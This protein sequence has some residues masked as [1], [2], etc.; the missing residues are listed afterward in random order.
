M[1]WIR[2]KNY[3]HLFPKLLERSPYHRRCK[4]L[5]QITELMRGKLL[6]FMDT[7]LQDWFVMDSMFIP[8]C[9]YA[10]ASRNLHFAY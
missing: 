9:V 10:R 1:A 4:D 2:Q 3:N 8:V 7:Q 5:Q 6:Y